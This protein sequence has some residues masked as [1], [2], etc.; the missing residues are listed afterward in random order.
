MEKFLGKK[1][2]IGPD[3]K[4]LL[5]GTDEVCSRDFTNRAT[6]DMRNAWRNDWVP[7]V[8]GTKT[9]TSGGEGNHT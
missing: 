6:F 2:T 4:S 7:L 5:I 3:K 8:A 1:F 9:A